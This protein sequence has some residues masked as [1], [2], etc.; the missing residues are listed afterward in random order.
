MG[1]NKK[2]GITVL[3]PFTN[4]VFVATQ[5]FWTAGSSAG[6]GN[7]SEFSPHLGGASV[8]IED[9][10][11][12]EKDSS[13]T[14]LQKSVKDCSSNRQSFEQF[15]FLL[16]IFWKNGKSSFEESPLFSQTYFLSPKGSQKSGRLAWRGE[17]GETCL[18]GVF[19]YKGE[20]DVALAMEKPWKP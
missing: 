19:G 2:L 17:N 11:T 3:L 20:S 14:F 12:R 10:P 9:A 15:F 1:I 5:D 7:P 8:G 16:G 4:R 6:P 13:S 18:Q